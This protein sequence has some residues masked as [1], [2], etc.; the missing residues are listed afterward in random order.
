MDVY[1]KEVALELRNASAASDSDCNV[2]VLVFARNNLRSYTKLLDK[3]G[4][5]RYYFGNIGK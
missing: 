1:G 3:V 2:L 4:M 5:N